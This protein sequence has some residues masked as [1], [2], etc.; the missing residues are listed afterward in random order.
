[1]TCRECAKRRAALSPFCSG[2]LRAVE[3][4]GHPRGRSL[5]PRE[6]AGER[7]QAER[8]LT[9]H[10]EHPAIEAALDFLRR[11]LDAA[12]R[13]EAVPGQRE[14]A[15]LAGH[16]VEPRAVLAEALALYLYSLA[17]PA[18]LPDDARLSFQIGAKALGLA[19]CEKRFSLA[20]GAGRYRSRP[21][22]KTAR[23]A[24]GEYLRASLMPLMVNV[25]AALEAENAA[26]QEY[27]RA[28]RQPFTESR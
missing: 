5:R 21:A 20:G 13:G 9:K 24:A 26:R 27:A 8:F 23:R 1:M 10:A 22:P 7:Q 6:Y 11:W 17:R 2:H 4:W 12:R 28:I 3:R 16:G 15:R 18:A 25:E 14:A 19:P